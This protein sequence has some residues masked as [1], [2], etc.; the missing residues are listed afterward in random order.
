MCGRNS[1]QISWS[2]MI[3]SALA[4]QE[5]GSTKI[6]L[7]VGLYLCCYLFNLLKLSN[8]PLSSH[9]AV[10]CWISLLI[11]G[12]VEPENWKKKWMPYGK[13]K[14]KVCIFLLVMLIHNE[15][16]LIKQS[17][18]PILLKRARGLFKEYLTWFFS[19]ETN[20]AQEVCCGREM[21][22]TF[23]CI[24]GFFPSSRQRQ[25]HAAVSESVN[26]AR[27]ALLFSAKMM[28]WLEQRYCIKFCQKLGDSQVETIQKIQRV[29]ADDAMSITQIKEWYNWFKDGHMSMESSARSGRPSTSQNDE[30]IGQVRTL[31]MQ[32]RRVTIQELAEEVGI[33]NGLV[34]SILTNDLALQR[35]SR[36]SCQ[37]C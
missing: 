15:C 14:S 11:V 32:D 4:F 18:H 3:I 16:S 35:L 24:H 5:N 12:R 31:V 30:L 25:S 23:M 10:E 19:A 36:N 37:S 9:P 13:I 8:N 22:S 29:F 33:S 26:A 21:E 2:Q 6:I 28:E 1:P 34:H 27:I 7:V 17:V 20:E